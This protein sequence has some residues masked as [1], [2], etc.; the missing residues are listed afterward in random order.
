M[1]KKNLAIFIVAAL[2]IVAIALLPLWSLLVG[3]SPRPPEGMPKAFMTN[4]ITR[5]LEMRCQAA[6]H[7]PVDAIPRVTPEMKTATPADA[8]F[9]VRDW[10]DK[11]KAGIWWGVIPSS[12]NFTRTRADGP[13]ETYE[14]T[15]DLV[16]VTESLTAGEPPQFELRHLKRTVFFFNEGNNQWRQAGF[17]SQVDD[18][19]YDDNI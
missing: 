7:S 11:D 5:Q 18:V 6:P 10:L 1:P 13:H 14:V 3:E 4:H 19:E 9:C 16:V 8:Y 17:A 15:Y 2:A 12:V